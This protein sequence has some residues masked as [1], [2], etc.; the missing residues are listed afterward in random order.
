MKK[1]EGLI[2]ATYTP[3]DAEG[4]LNAALIPAYADYLKKSGVDG[5]FVNGT[6]GEGVSLTMEE[7]IL[8][9]KTWIAQK[10]ADFKV[11]IHVGHNSL[12]VAQQLAQHAAQ[13]GA[14]GIGAM[15]PAF[16]K[17]SNLAALVSYNA[18]IA[19]AAPTLP[20]FYY[21]IPEM[22]GADFPMIDFLVAAEK[23]I[24]NLAGIKFTYHNLMDMKLCQE[25]AGQKYS[26]LHGRDEVLICAMALG[27]RG[28]IGS[29]YNYIAP[30]FVKMMEAFECGDLSVANKFQFKAIEIIQ[31]LIKYGGGVK[32]GKSIIRMQGLDLGSP[33][34]PVIGLSDAEET[35]LQEEL[36]ALSFQNYSRSF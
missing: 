5:V 22:T 12:R 2:A 9:A 16:F 31:L 29:T 6:T 4:N 35:A 32:A 15:A 20:Y 8:A 19:S 24:P 33:R 25:Y 3:F 34:S 11:M 18:S 30:L 23:Q 13:L 36:R 14:D 1:V 26:I 28:A 27:V 17:P 21:H 10:S 7:R